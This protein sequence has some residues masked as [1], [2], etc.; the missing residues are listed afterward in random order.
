MLL[1]LTDIALP[2]TKINNKKLAFFLRWIKLFSERGKRKRER[3]NTNSKKLVV[4]FLLAMRVQ[5]DG[6]CP[7]SMAFHH[8]PQDIALSSR[9]PCDVY[10]VYFLS[11]LVIFFPAHQPNLAKDSSNI[12][13][14]GGF[15]LH[16]QTRQIMAEPSSRS[17]IFFPCIF[18]T[19][20]ERASH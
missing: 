18:L 12:S 2:P 11:L 13:M 17:A 16:R 6:K 15:G 4:F 7:A 3:K 20:R 14:T 8:F 19:F 9:D 10:T 5:L 1:N